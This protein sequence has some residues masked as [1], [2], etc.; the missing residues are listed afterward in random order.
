M[1]RYWSVDQSGGL[2]DP[3][4]LSKHVYKVFTKQLL[5]CSDLYELLE[6]NGSLHQV[7]AE[8]QL[9]HHPVLH[10]VEATH[11][12]LQVSCDGAGEFVTAKHVVDELHLERREQW[13]S[14]INYAHWNSKTGCIF[15]ECGL[16]QK[17]VKHVKH[18]S[19]EWNIFFY[20]ISSNEQRVDV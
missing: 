18:F 1:L 16:I 15:N 9:G 7:F 20:Q 12:P 5:H 10:L 13:D 4:V 3:T 8:A 14:D 19:A 6:Q 17:H 11:E 2:T